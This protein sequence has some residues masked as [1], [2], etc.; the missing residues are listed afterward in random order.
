MCHVPAAPLRVPLLFCRALSLSLLP[1]LS[2]HTPIFVHVVGYR[3]T[4]RQLARCYITLWACSAAKR[5]VSLPVF[6]LTR[7]A[8]GRTT[9][10]ARVPTSNG[11]LCTTSSTAVQL[12]GS[13]QLNVSTCPRVCNAVKL[14]FVRFI[15]APRFI[16]NWA[17][18]RFRF[19][20][21]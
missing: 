16:R 17:C 2:V 20:T 7:A 3:S 4:V 21:W 1:H 13:Q 10:F 14:L 6:C 12:G 11:W 18:C 8:R 9:N 5:R 15:L 19:L